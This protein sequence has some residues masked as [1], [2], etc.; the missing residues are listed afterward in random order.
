MLY[1]VFA[2]LVEFVVVGV[3]SLFSHTVGFYTGLVFALVDIW[4]FWLSG[5]KCPQNCRAMLL[6]VG[7]LVGDVIQPGWFFKPW[8]PFIKFG[9]TRIFGAMFFTT[10]AFKLTYETDD[11]HELRSSERQLLRVFFTVFLELPYNEAD[12]LRKIVEKKVPLEELLLIP[13]FEDIIMPI[14]WRVFIK[15]GYQEAI[16]LGKDE[17]ALLA[18]NEK[19]SQQLRADGSILR[20]LG[21][22]GRDASDTT[23]GSGRVWLEFE[24][25]LGGKDLE[26]AI[27]APAIAK[28]L[29]VAARATAARKSEEV[30]GQVL[31]TVAR[32][33]GMTMEVLEKDLKKHP[34][35]GRPGGDYYEAFAFARAQTARDRAGEL[36]ELSYI[37]IVSAGGSVEGGFAA[38][39]GGLESYGRAKSGKPRRDDGGQGKRGSKGFRGKKVVDPDDEPEETAEQFHDRTGFWPHWDE[40]HRQPSV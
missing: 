33:L 28:E 38:L 4:V 30:G 39:V 9:G 15:M 20:A 5:D 2:L 3:T 8:I 25:I 11:K 36:G 6:R 35:K 7:K 34:E 24:K 21:V 40:Q 10:E 13:Y 27:A 26:D 12:S 19:V 17:D 18:L 29:A 32:Q 22:L 14:L 31:G 1:F 16:S 23:E 37:D